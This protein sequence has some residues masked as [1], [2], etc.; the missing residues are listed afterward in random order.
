MQEARAGLNPHFIAAKQ[1][2][3]NQTLAVAGALVGTPETFFV[4]CSFP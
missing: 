3:L 2:A 4:Q 1:H